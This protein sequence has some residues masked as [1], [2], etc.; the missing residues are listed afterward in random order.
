[1]NITGWY[2]LHTNGSLIYKNDPDAIVDIRESDLCLSAWP[3]DPEDR[4]CAWNLLVEALSLGVDKSRIDELASKWFCDNEDAV[5]YASRVG[6]ILGMD[7]NKFTA[8]KADFI[9]LQESPCGFG[10][11]YLE[12]M[13]DL[14]K[15]LG[16]KGGKMWNST[17]GSLLKI[18]EA[19]E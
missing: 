15:Q 16:Y 14:C 5:E 7:G 2:Y 12:A 17:F 4:L 1:M 8:T 9:N 11:S 6:A 3:V 13:A 18:K 19:T 10:N